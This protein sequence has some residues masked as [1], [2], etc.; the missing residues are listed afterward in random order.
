MLPLILYVSSFPPYA[1]MPAD[2]MAHQ[3]YG[4]APDCLGAKAPVFDLDLGLGLS[5]GKSL[6]RHSA[7]VLHV[8]RVTPE[9]G[10]DASRALR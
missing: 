7:L 3:A 9:S 2:N 4:G 1:D 6:C 8:I 10:P 5:R